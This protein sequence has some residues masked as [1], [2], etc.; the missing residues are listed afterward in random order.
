MRARIWCV[1]LV[2][3]FLV[4]ISAAQGPEALAALQGRWVVTA[5]QHDGKPLDVIKGGVITIAGDAFEIRT[6]SGRVLQG[7]LRAD[8]AQQPFQLDF[9][10]ADGARWEGI[11]EI[12]DGGAGFRMNYVEAGGSDAR[13]AVFTTSDK[14]EET[15]V[16]VRRETR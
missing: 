13:P 5:G 9:L 1:S 14:T 8:T 4:S 15:I 6:A 12:T 10:H 16:V 3:M 7:T 11:Y 2:V